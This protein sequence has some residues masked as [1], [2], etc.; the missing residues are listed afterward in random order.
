MRRFDRLFFS[1]FSGHKDKIEQ[2]PPIQQ[3]FR[4]KRSIVD[5]SNVID[6]ESQR[7]QK[8]KRS[9]ESLVI[10]LDDDDED[11]GK[12]ATVAT[13]TSC[14]NDIAEPSAATP[15]NSLLKELAAERQSREQVKPKAEVVEAVPSSL[16]YKVLTYNVWFEESVCMP[17]RMAALGNIIDAEMADFV[18][19]QVT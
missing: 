15:M 5:V 9:S 13:V 12:T 1:F 16:S 4:G 19:L 6:I 3:A 14:T 7:E 11:D 8:R 17:Q 2:G 10:V 18:F